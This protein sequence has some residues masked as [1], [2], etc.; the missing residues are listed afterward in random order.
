[1]GER[2]SAEKL[3]PSIAHIEFSQDEGFRRRFA[4][5]QWFPGEGE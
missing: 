4:T 1:M 2:A 3:A 5:A